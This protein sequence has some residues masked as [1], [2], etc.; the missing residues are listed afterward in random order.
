[1]D[2]V[3]A[4]RQCGKEEVWTAGRQKWWY[5]VAK[6]SIHSQ[7]VLCR[8]CRR[9]KREKSAEARRIHLEGVARKRER[10]RK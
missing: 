3:V 2:K 1:M 5:E 7:A 10:T 6:G 9:T 4:C 8:S